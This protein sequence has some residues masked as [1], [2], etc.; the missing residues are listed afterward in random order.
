MN[1]SQLHQQ[2]RQQ[3]RARLEAYLIAAEGKIWAIEVDS[4]VTI[5]EHDLIA[6]WIY[7]ATNPDRETFVSQLEAVPTK[8]WNGNRMVLGNLY[9]GLGDNVFTG[10]RIAL[11]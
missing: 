4:A 10:R 11:G 5:A 1:W 8:Y 2:I 6:G 9:A 3:A 7:E